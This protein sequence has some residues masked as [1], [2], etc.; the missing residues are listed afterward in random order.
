MLA[1]LTKKIVHTNRC[2]ECEKRNSE[3]MA[4][5]SGFL[6]RTRK[7]RQKRLLLCGDRRDWIIASA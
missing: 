1:M 5:L 4:L 2:V 6:T 3:L 7:E